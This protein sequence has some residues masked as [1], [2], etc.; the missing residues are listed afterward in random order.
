MDLHLFGTI[1]PHAVFPEVR[2]SAGA[3]RVQQRTTDSWV[4]LTKPL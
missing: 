1:P 4:S 2:R 3:V